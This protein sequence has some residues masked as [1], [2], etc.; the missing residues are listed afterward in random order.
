MI[1][2]LYFIVFYLFILKNIIIVYY[3]RE[4]NSTIGSHISLSTN[5]IIVK[6]HPVVDPT[7]L[8]SVEKVCSVSDFA[9]IENDENSDLSFV[10]PIKR[11]KLTRELASLLEN[12][13]LDLALS[14]KA[15]SKTYPRRTSIEEKEVLYRFQKVF[16]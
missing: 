8:S 12:G 11:T 3:F 7:L 10:P 5:E 9:K 13:N 1:K 6:I 16:F 15:E 14:C 4:S 2:N